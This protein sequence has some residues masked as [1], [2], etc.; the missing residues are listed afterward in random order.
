MSASVAERTIERDGMPT[1]RRYWAYG[2]V[3][4]TLTLAVMDASVANVA[5][6]T[7]AGD[8]HAS[9]SDSIAIVSAYQMTI[10][11]LLLPLAALGDIYGYRHVYSAGVAVFTLASLCCAAAWTLDL[12]TAARVLQGLGAA[13]IMSVNTAL[14][15]YIFP[16]SKL[17]QAIGINTMVVAVSSTVGPSFAS[18]MLGLASWHWLFAINVP[19]GVVAFFVGVKT[20]P[21]SRKGGQRFDVLS[22]LLTA[23]MFGMVILFVE[24]FSNPTPWPQKIA[25]AVIGLAAGVAAVRRQAKKPAPLLPVD[26]LKI[27]V[28]ALSM[29]A[30]IGAFSAQMLA[31]VSLPFFLQTGLGY[32]ATEV[33]FLIMPWPLAI[34][35]TAPLAGR[36]SDRISAALLG[37]LGMAAFAIGLLCLAFVPAHAGAFDIGWRMVICGFGFGLFQSPNNRTIITAA[38]R[39]R[40]GAASGMLGTARLLGQATGAALVAV[41]LAAIA[42][43]AGARLCLAIAAAC[44]ACAGIFSV[45]RASKAEPAA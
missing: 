37:C 35:F 15:R 23:A 22:A 38:P 25:E 13:G 20:L 6:P 10:V 26:L 19:I 42:G 44:A 32:R 33:G 21:D 14:I 16:A 3:I 45:L 34:A 1:P 5:L 31:Y 27:P 11:I 4:L 24:S 28:F 17:G 8:F 9:P 29:C 39:L 40:S 30:S 7:I 36:L 12:L 18:I 43:P 41:I 2:A